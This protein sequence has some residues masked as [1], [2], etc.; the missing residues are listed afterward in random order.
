MGLRFGDFWV[1][2]YTLRFRFFGLEVGVSGWTW[3]P[4]DSPA[5]CRKTKGGIIAKTHKRARTRTRT[6]SSSYTLTMHVCIHYGEM[7]VNLRAPKRRKGMRKETPT[8][9]QNS[10]YIAKKGL[11]FVIW[12]LHFGVWGLGL[13]FRATGH[14]ARWSSP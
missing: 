12:V 14:W 4:S 3:L 9:G 10:I 8:P 1:R 13:R 11:G 6:D 5:N 2:V 7:R